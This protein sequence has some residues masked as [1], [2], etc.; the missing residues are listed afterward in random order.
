MEVKQLRVLVEDKEKELSRCIA[1]LDERKVEVFKLRESKAGLFAL[2]QEMSSKCQQKD[3]EIFSLRSDLSK[4]TQEAVDH[5][6]L[7][8]TSFK[9]ESSSQE[10]YPT[11]SREVLQLQ[12]AADVK[13]STP[14]EPQAKNQEEICEEANDEFD[15]LEEAI[16]SQDHIVKSKDEGEMIEVMREKS[17]S[18]LQ[19]EREIARAEKSY[20]EL[21][22]RGG[23]LT[24]HEETKTHKGHVRIQ[25]EGSTTI[26][27]SFKCHSCSVLE[28]ER[29][30]LIK[31]VDELRSAHY[32]QQNVCNKALKYCASFRLEHD[33]LKV[34]VRKLNYKLKKLQ[35][36]LVVSLAE[37][38]NA[39][40]E[41][42]LLKAKSDYQ[43]EAMKN[44]LSVQGVLTHESDRASSTNEML[45]KE[46]AQLKMVHAKV[47][48]KINQGT[49]QHI[50]LKHLM[51]DVLCYAEEKEEQLKKAKEEQALM[52]KENLNISSELIKVSSRNIILELEIANSCERTLVQ[53]STYSPSGEKKNSKGQESAVRTGTVKFKDAE[54]CG[55]I[56]PIKE[57]EFELEVEKINSRKLAE[58]HNSDVEKIK[59]LE[60]KLEQCNDEKQTKLLELKLAIEEV[61]MKLQDQTEI[62][63]QNMQEMES[64]DTRIARLEEELVATHRR[65]EKEEQDL[66][67]VTCKFKDVS[68]HCDFLKYENDNLHEKVHKMEMS[69][70]ALTESQSPGETKA[71]HDEMAANAN[72]IQQGHLETLVEEEIQD[73]TKVFQ[74][75]ENEME[76]NGN[77]IQVSSHEIMVERESSD[78]PLEIRLIEKYSSESS[79]SIPQTTCTVQEVTLSEEELENQCSKLSTN[80]CKTDC[81][82]EDDIIKIST[83][84]VNNFLRLMRMNFIL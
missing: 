59:D 74:D 15:A 17:F 66:E 73:E 79:T 48:K 30:N 29:A 84:E 27:E 10:R 6:K 45:R 23:E 53:K 22:K 75:R 40:K 56:Q 50:K 37:K 82:E 12:R 83:K 9:S 19:L 21:K 81:S 68:E 69:H 13:M 8:P 24:L 76:A 58:K 51:N 38:E 41:A 31:Q 26:E 71:L 43:V 36:L 34:Q 20:E 46:L 4:Y 78:S 25:R 52:A 61:N 67:S 35:N 33:T 62:S 80:I 47:L 7:G 42:V 64:K 57:L 18:L 11:I 1:L 2:V 3:E 5:R 14:E 32:L 16:E 49:R 55:Y 72:E 28:Q 63:V 60:A 77:E 39:V 65:H 44:E 54:F 70:E